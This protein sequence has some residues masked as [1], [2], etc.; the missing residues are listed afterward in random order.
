MII[1]LMLVQISDAR[2][3]RISHKLILLCYIL[4]YY[5]RLNYYI[6]LC[7]FLVYNILLN[8]IILICVV[9]YFV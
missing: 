5:I 4:F 2:N 6:L 3:F 1:L 9:V 7:N 8:Y